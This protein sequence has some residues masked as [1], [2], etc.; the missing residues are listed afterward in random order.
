MTECCLKE[1]LRR[2]RSWMGLDFPAGRVGELT[3]IDLSGLLRGE[4]CVM[5]F[6]IVPDVRPLRH[7]I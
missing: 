3:Y 1:K 4:G 7:L 5:D 6:C 2:R